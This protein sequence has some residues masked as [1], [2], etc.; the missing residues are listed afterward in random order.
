MNGP[1]PP[2]ALTVNPPSAFPRHDGL[3]MAAKL[4]LI[5]VGEVIVN[6]ESITLLMSSLSLTNR[7]YDPEAR[8]SNSGLS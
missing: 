1:V 8:F 6:G 3:L 7:V 5:A 2:D 4:M